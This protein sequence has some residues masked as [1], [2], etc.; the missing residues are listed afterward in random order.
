MATNP[1]LFCL[2]HLQ[3]NLYVRPDDINKDVPLLVLQHLDTLDNISM[4]LFRFVGKQLQ[5]VSSDKYVHPAYGT[6][7]DPNTDISN[8]PLALKMGADGDRSSCS[9]QDYGGPLK[10]LLTGDY[11]YFVKGTKNKQLVWQKYRRGESSEEKNPY[12][13]GEQTL[14]NGFVFVMVEILV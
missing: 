12:L 13:A 6:K 10:I 11:D 14:E 3:S 4:F 2:L 7:T 8:V 1:R 5:H 9:I